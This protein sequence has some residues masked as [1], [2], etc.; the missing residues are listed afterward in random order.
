MHIPTGMPICLETCKFSKSS[1]LQTMQ[2]L[3]VRWFGHH[4]KH[5]SGWKAHHL[6]CV[7][8]IDGNSEPFGFVDPSYVIRAAHPI[9]VFA[10]CETEGL[11]DPSNIARCKV[12][13]D[14]DWRF[15]YVSM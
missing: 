6:H 5:R 4:A 7:S 15:Y 9:P 1:Q 11:L 14:E 8:F 3:H 2:F 12:D 10:F 13:G